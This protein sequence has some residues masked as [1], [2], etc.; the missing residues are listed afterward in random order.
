MDPLSAVA[1]RELREGCLPHHAVKGRKQHE[2]G[3]QSPS[4]HSELQKFL[5]AAGLF[6]CITY[7]RLHRYHNDEH[8]IFPVCTL[9]SDSFHTLD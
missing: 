2:G 8:N 1:E 3:R 6:M 7:V 5:S 9:T 4:R